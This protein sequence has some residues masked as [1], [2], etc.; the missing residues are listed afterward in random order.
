MPVEKSK[1]A[2]YQRRWKA[3]E[4]DPVAF[5]ID[6]FGWSSFADWQKRNLWAVAHRPRV[7]T[8][9]AQGTGKGVVAA[10]ALLHHIGTRNDSKGAVYS[11]G[12]ETLK[13]NVWAEI[14]KLYQRSDQFQRM[15]EL[16][17]TQ[18]VSRA[19]PLTHFI[20]ARTAA[21]RYSRSDVGGEKIAEGA[22]G[23]YAD[24]TL[25]VVD[26]ATSPE[27]AI[28]DALEGTASTPRRR[29]FYEGNP[30]RRSGRFAD[31]FLR[32]AFSR[33]WV[34]F[35][36]SKL[37][38]PWTNTAEAR[39]L[40]KAD[41]QRYGPESAY[42][43]ARIWGRF[44]RAG[45]IDTLVTVDD[46]ML[47]YARGCVLDAAGNVVQLP[48]DDR[49]LPLDIGI[50]P[51]RYGDDLC[52]FVVRR[53]LIVLDLVTLPKSSEPEIRRVAKALARKYQG[54]VEVGD[55][56]KKRRE[57]ADPRETTRFRIDE[58]S[59]GGGAALVDNLR[60]EGWVVYAVD[61]GRSPVDPIAERT[62]KNLGAAVWANGAEQL[63][64]ISLAGVPE[65]YRT[66]LLNQ[67]V[68]R[69]YRHSKGGKQRM[70]L[71]SKEEMRQRGLGSPDLADAAMLC[72]V[73]L[74]QIGVGDINETIA[75][76]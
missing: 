50:D 56:E 36:V 28:F 13:T 5:L 32:K 75:I 53:G 52:A 73:D 11:A 38:S 3:Y 63:K 48:A 15:F 67:L 64:R 61:N 12:R 51:A 40:W 19:R 55:G 17:A 1:V 74:D 31:V 6:V 22:A 68:T 27:D 71:V 9:G 76:L 47:A 35:F 65:R 42:V 72:F 14:A 24:D 7:A 29:L 70:E 46:V 2:E 34:H 41:I 8:A 33:G 10:G 21:A 57:P 16:T 66:L 60:E 43:Q 62:Y 25:V 69:Q 39:A 37:D 23:M 26:E 30:V 20:V 59:G 49:L 58:G 18:I 4:A 54:E 45:T 44:P